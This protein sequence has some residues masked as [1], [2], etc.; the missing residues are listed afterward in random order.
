MKHPA[1]FETDERTSKRMSKVKLKRG[2]AEVKIAKLLWHKGYRYR[3]N[4]KKLP[5]SPDIAILRYKIAVFID[6]E[7]WHGKDWEKRKNGLKRNRDYW[8]EKIEEN[9]A[10]DSTVDKELKFLGWIPIRFWAKDVMK[11]KERC[12]DAIDELVFEEVLLTK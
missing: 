5:G 9:M 7:F 2:E 8:I 11:N 12:V 10:R 6:G 4:F 3:L 1:S